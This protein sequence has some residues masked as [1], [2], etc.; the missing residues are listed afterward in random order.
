MLPERKIVHTNRRSE[1]D[2]AGIAV[3]DECRHL[4]IYLIMCLLWPPA[5]SF[6]FFSILIVL[7]YL[8]L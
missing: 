1:Q 2:A 6:A 7:L 8:F 5:A 4:F 3:A